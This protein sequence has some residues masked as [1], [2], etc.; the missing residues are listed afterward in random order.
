MLSGPTQHGLQLHT[1]AT[2]HHTIAFNVPR[3]PYYAR[4]T[5]LMFRRWQQVARQ[6]SVTLE[7]ARARNNVAAADRLHQPR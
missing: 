1:P 2:L 3:T 6:R 5:L 4:D 7:A